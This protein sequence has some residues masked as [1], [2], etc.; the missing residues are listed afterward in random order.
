MNIEKIRRITLLPV[1]DTNTIEEIEELGQSVA[2]DFYIKDIENRGTEIPGGYRCG[3]IVNV[4]HHA[5]VERMAREISSTPLAVEYLS[6]HTVSDG[7]RIV[8]NHTDADSV[9]SAGIIAGVLEPCE[10]FCHAAIAADHTGKVNTIADLLQP[11]VSL[12]DFQFSFRNLN[13]LLRGEKLDDKAK[14]LMHG[15]LTE[16]GRCAEAASAFVRRGRVTYLAGSRFDSTEFFPALFP[17]AEVILVHYPAT[18]AQ[19]NEVRLRLGPAAPKGLWLNRLN[20]PNFGG[21]WNAG[22]SRRGE[23][24]R[25]SAVEYADIVTEKADELIMQRG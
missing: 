22:S 2:C 1:K 10:E 19:G 24:T 17:D 11:L 23:K 13:L 25:L 15:R 21:R 7:E 5:P 12:R 4:D 6:T 9:L 20:L 18:G 8:T 3:K 14:T 16:R